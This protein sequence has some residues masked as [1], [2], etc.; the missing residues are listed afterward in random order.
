MLHV[1]RHYLPIRKAILI[2]SETVL[3]T[4]V[5][6]L[7]LSAHCWNDPAREVQLRVFQAGLTLEDAA[8]RSI[9]NSFLVAL[10][11]QLALAFNEL[12]DFRRSSGGVERFTGFVA[13]SGIAL[14]A[15]TALVLLTRLWGLETVLDFPGLTLSQTI[16]SLLL[17]LSLGFGVLFL[18]RSLFQRLVHSWGLEERV[19][20]LGTSNVARTLVH[21]LGRRA[22]YQVVGVLPDPDPRSTEGGDP[23][24]G[25]VRFGGHGGNG[26]AP[27][28]RREPGAPAERNGSGERHGEL[29]ALPLAQGSGPR[30]GPALAAARAVPQGSV[31]SSEAEVLAEQRRPGPTRRPNPSVP[32]DRP[33]EGPP[34]ELPLIRSL[35]GESLLQLAQRLR[36]DDLV[37][38]LED[39]RGTMPTEDLLRCRLAGIVVEEGEALYERVTGKIAVAAMRPSYLIFNQG[40]SRHPFSDLAKRTFDITC[41]VLGILLTWPVMVLTAIAVK[42]DSKGPALFRQERSGRFG[43]PIIVNKF[44]SMR[45]DAEQATGPVWASHNDP[46]ITRVGRFIRKSRLDELPQLFNVLG[47]SM[48]MVGPRPERPHFI[49][50]LSQQ[51]PYYHQR[52]IVKPGVTGW[53]QINY[54]YGNTVEDALQKLQYDLF[55]IKYHSVP[56]DLSICVQTIRTV[57]LRKGT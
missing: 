15:V 1:L 25:A 32:A 33:L 44:R 8:L 6:G 53:A 50:D 21:E 20:I 39:R 7:F 12:Y 19:L 4:A 26:D 55:Y 16:Q 43:Q 9:F 51:I 35:P 34:A 47:G 30:R 5:I 37:V 49:A 31:A 42:L 54:P 29:R 36:V 24:G 27:R 46:R 48:S 17:A 52:H 22:G 13:S 2:A 45:T 41:A 56:F 23:L 57:L 14:T 10:V 3:L 38:A 11:A 28:R 40:F 18:W